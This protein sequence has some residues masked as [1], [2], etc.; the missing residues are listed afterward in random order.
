MRTARANI[1]QHQTAVIQ[2]R[3]RLRQPNFLIGKPVTIFPRGTRLC[4]RDELQVSTKITANSK[5]NL[6]GRNG[7]CR[8]ARLS[9]SQPCRYLAGQMFTAVRNASRIR[10]TNKY[11]NQYIDFATIED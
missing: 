6:T 2:S 3:R 7:F 8:L 11:Y 1:G 4:S 9:R 5:R 10:A